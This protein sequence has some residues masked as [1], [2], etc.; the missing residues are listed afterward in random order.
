MSDNPSAPQGE[1]PRIDL[2]DTASVEHWTRTLAVTRTQL[3]ESVDR[4]GPLADE[5]ELDLKGARTSTLA[6]Q[7]DPGNTLD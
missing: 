5:V 2:A 6:E 1:R 7:V 4:V 3:E